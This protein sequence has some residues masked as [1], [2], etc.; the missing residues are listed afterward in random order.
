MEKRELISHLKRNAESGIAPLSDAYVF[1]TTIFDVRL[2]PYG[3]VR[4]SPTKMEFLPA[5]ER[6][7]GTPMIG[8]SSPEPSTYRLSI[9]E[10]TLLHELYYPSLK[11][12][13]SYVKKMQIAISAVIGWC[14]KNNQ[15]LK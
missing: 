14:S 9:N 6:T 15:I 4:V 3:N 11:K 7:D 10:Y 1:Q 2:F 8:K 5:F 13:I 12:E